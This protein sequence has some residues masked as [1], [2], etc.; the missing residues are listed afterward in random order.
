[1]RNSI[2]ALMAQAAMLNQDLQSIQLRMNYFS[3]PEFHPK[4]HTV[5]SYS[6]QN[7]IAKSKRRRNGR[8]K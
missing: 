8:K 6:K 4:K 1:M 2:F 7:R 3:S 5:M